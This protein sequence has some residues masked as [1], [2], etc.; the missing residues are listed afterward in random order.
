LFQSGIDVH[1]ISAER[2][3]KKEEK[4]IFLDLVENEC[5]ICQVLITTSVLDCGINI[6]DPSLKNIVIETFDKTS[7]LQ[8]LGRIRIN[9]YSTMINLYIYEFSTRTL[10]GHK[11]MLEEKLKTGVLFCLHNKYEKYKSLGGTEYKGIHFLSDAE[12]KNLS[13]PVNKSRSTYYCIQRHIRPIR[14]DPTEDPLF[15]KVQLNTQAALNDLYLLYN[16][17]IAFSKRKMC[18]TTQEREITDDHFF[19]KY[20]LSWLGK[21]YDENCWIDYGDDK[22]E[23]IDLLESNLNCELEREQH[24]AF[25]HKCIELLYR[26]P[27]IMPQM[28]ANKKRFLDPT[29]AAKKTLNAAFAFH[30]LNYNIESYYKTNPSTKKREAFWVVRRT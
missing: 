10:N 15:F 4:G 11:H 6:K 18:S 14:Y 16:L 23:F 7:F 9:D 21:E 26:L 30:N 3:S 13:Y 5:F 27:N 8:M 2:I 29:S 17:D 22:K 12:I 25:S 20:Q 28:K 24:L 1:F 19:L